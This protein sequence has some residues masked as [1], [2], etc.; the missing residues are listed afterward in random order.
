VVV[1]LVTAAVAP[2]AVAAAVLGVTGASSLVSAVLERDLVLRSFTRTT[3]SL[4]LNLG[5]VRSTEA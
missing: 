2:G 3:T 4:G 1:A 5:S